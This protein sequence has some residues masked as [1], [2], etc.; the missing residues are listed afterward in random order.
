[1]AYTKHHQNTAD[2]PASDT[3]QMRHGRRLRKAEIL[4]GISDYVRAWFSARNE[5]TRVTRAGARVVRYRDTDILWVAPSGL[6]FRL[7]NGGVP[8]ADVA[9]HMTGA[10]GRL[11]PAGTPAP[12]VSGASS[13]MQLWAPQRQYR[14]LPFSRSLEATYRDGVWHAQPDGLIAPVPLE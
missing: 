11:L 10:L 4:S 3:P 12:R 2:D 13:Q 8:L 7:D 6:A 14:Y 5:V 9:R 1:M